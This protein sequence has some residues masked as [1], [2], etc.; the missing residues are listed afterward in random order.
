MKASRGINLVELLVTMAIIFIVAGGVFRLILG[1]GMFYGVGSAKVTAQEHARIA[2]L[3]MA[4]E[5]RETASAV[6]FIRNDPAISGSFKPVTD[7]G[8]P[9]RFS[10]NRVLFQ[11]PCR[12]P[13]SGTVGLYDQ[14]AGGH[15]QADVVFGARDAQ[16]NWQDA[17]GNWNNNLWIEYAVI[18]NQLRRRVWKSSNIDFGNSNGVVISANPEFESV[19]SA[20]I[21]DI[22]FR[23]F[24][25]SFLD[26]IEIVV[27]GREQVSARAGEEIT[28]TADTELFLRN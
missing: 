6:L 18:N 7:G 4:L 24:R 27:T 28:A 21:K 9:A 1:G 17:G 10:G 16:G 14:A 15:N 13:A 26:Q 11:V 5:L 23:G 3:R 22:S 19:L 20:F 12:E 25:Q 2:L 8:S